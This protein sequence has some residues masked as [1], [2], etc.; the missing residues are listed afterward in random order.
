MNRFRANPVLKVMKIY[1]KLLIIN[2]AMTCVAYYPYW[3]DQEAYSNFS[4]F[5]SP[6][7]ES[8]LLEVL[9]L[10]IDTLAPRVHRQQISS[11]SGAFSSQVHSHFDALELQL[12]VEGISELLLITAA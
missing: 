1:E 2:F 6:A 9:P 5:R 10:D 12:R 3:I 11:S 7:F 8:A 4:N